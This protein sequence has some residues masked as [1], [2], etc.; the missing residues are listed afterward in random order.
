MPLPYP[1]LPSEL[2]EKVVGQ[3][4]KEPTLIACSQVSLTFEHYSF[5]QLFRCLRLCCD[6]W[7]IGTFSRLMP[8]SHRIFQHV[9]ELRIGCSMVPGC[10]HPSP[11]QIDESRY[12]QLCLILKLFA[13][14][15][16]GCLERIT[17][18]RVSWG[19]LPGSLQTALTGLLACPSVKKLKFEH[20]EG[21]PLSAFRHISSG[22]K[23][24]QICNS[25]Y[26]P[27]P[28]DNALAED[29]DTFAIPAARPEQLI[30]T[31][32]GS[33]TGNLESGLIDLLDISHLTMLCMVVRFDSEWELLQ[34]LMQNASSTLEFVSVVFQSVHPYY[35]PS[36]FTGDQIQL[37]DTYRLGLDLAPFQ[38]LRNID[39]WVP[40]RVRTIDPILRGLHETLSSLP[41]GSPLEH[42]TFFSYLESTPF[43]LTDAEWHQLDVKLSSAA[44]RATALKHIK[45]H[46]ARFMNQ[47]PK[48]QLVLYDRTTGLLREKLTM[49]FK[50]IVTERTTESLAWVGLY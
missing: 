7:A 33:E 46:F 32:K 47:T 9:K 11:A 17:L 14:H 1:T 49:S 26:N 4:G 50:K 25:G 23:K 43:E 6:E 29:I 38:R 13:E 3:I 37:Q 34:K 21:F 45:F 41:N 5:R 16:S 22:L 15:S 20:V 42:I 31:S 8:R 36:A 48:E 2:I 24:F 39:F 18:R 28:L 27:H 12:Q 35:M 40:L 10:L 19:S 30:I 44:L